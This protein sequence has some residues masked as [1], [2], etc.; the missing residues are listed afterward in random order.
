[1]PI[2]P[3]PW[4]HRPGYETAFGRRQYQS[5]SVATPVGY[6]RGVHLLDR[7]T[8][9]IPWAAKATERRCRS[10][11]GGVPHPAPPS[12]SHSDGGSA[13]RRRRQA[14]G[15]MRCGDQC[16]ADRRRACLRQRRPPKAAGRCPNLG[17]GPVIPIDGATQPYFETRSFERLAA[18]FEKMPSSDA[19]SGAKK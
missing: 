18:I 19:S 2:E 3:E 16:S 17:S 1:M 8:P 14:I 15:A 9:K 4:I 5:L 10:V 6:F 7:A 13:K 11:I 12:T